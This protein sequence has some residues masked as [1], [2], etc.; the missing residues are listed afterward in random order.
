MT[1]AIN[2]RDTVTVRINT[3]VLSF[4]G[5]DSRVLYAGVER[6]P[7]NARLTACTG[8]ASDIACIVAE[9][10]HRG[11]AGNGW[12]HSANERA[13]FRREVKA[14]EKAYGITPRS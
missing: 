13:A 3:R 4:L 8:K 2:L 7:F 12:T 9:L 1:N 14:I 6:R 10:A 5:L 11:R